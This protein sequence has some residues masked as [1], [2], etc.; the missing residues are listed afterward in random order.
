MLTA[1]QEDAL[2]K[3][4]RAFGWDKWS[5]NEVG[6]LLWCAFHYYVRRLK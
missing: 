1:E 2:A 4:A 3:V 6:L 5:V